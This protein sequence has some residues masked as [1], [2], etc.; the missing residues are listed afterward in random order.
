MLSLS[1]LCFYQKHW[2]LGEYFFP[3]SFCSAHSDRGLCSA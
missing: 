3:G 1:F 2:V